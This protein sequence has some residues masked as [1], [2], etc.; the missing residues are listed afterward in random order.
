[1]EVVCLGPLTTQPTLPKMQAANPKGTG[2]GVRDDC[3]QWSLQKTLGLRVFNVRVYSTMS[4][5][6]SASERALRNSKLNRSLF[7]I[8]QSVK[9]Q[10][11]WKGFFQFTSPDLPQKAKRSPLLLLLSHL[12]FGM[13]NSWSRWEGSEE[14]PLLLPFCPVFNLLLLLKGA[15]L[16]CGCVAGTLW[17]CLT[18]V[19]PW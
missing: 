19:L 17:R 2:L 3:P 4:W 5:R 16:K 8:V 10:G 15:S 11:T 14:T 18:S 7:A 1:M 9:P 12:Y 13:C 6:D